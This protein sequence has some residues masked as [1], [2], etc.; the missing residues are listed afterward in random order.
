MKNR[1]ILLFALLTGHLAFAQ[2]A[3]IEI[4][5]SAGYTFSSSTDWGYASINVEDNYSVGLA[6]DIRVREDV[7]IELMFNRLSTN[8]TAQENNGYLGTTNY[9]TPVD[10]EYYHIGGVREFSSEKIRPFTML[11]LGGTRMHATGKTEVSQDL[12]KLQTTQDFSDVWTFSATLGGG[13]KIMFSE[14]IGLRLQARLLMPFY[15]N[16][17]GVYCGGGCGGGASFGVYF[18]QMDFTGGLVIGLG[19]Y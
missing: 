12:S 18:L 8:S 1:S 10:I 16:G 11:T 19:D 2:D 13:A 14:R 15:F 6:A 5:P 4:T 17:I 7:L 3:K 9:E